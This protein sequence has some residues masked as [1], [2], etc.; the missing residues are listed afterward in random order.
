MFL[1]G[2]PFSPKL[3]SYPIHLFLWKISEENVELI[4]LIHDSYLFCSTT[5]TPKAFDNGIAGFPL[6]NHTWTSNLTVAY[7]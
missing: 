4:L 6:K 3:E 7:L 2:L 1:F 5:S